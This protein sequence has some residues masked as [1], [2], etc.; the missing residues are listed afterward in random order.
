MNGRAR[1]K[2]PYAYDVAWDPGDV[3][4]TLIVQS[5][6]SADR[7]L[8]LYETSPYISAWT[9]GADGYRLTSTRDDDQAAR[10]ARQMLAFDDYVEK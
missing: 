9:T 1:T 7:R 10:D 5:G 3:H 8:R 2:R 6:Q 4:D